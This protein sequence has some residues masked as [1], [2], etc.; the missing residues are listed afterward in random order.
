MKEGKGEILNCMTSWLQAENF[1]MWKILPEVDHSIKW[2]FHAWGVTYCLDCW[3]PMWVWLQFYPEDISAGM[4]Q[5][6]LPEAARIK[7]IKISILRILQHTTKWRIIDDP[8][9]PL[10]C[11]IFYSIQPGVPLILLYDCRNTPAPLLLQFAFFAWQ[12]SANYWEAGSMRYNPLTPR[13]V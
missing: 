6:E 4:L 1:K 5:L 8:T 9:F 2:K 13:S 11:Q 12:L 7:C 10:A 3:M